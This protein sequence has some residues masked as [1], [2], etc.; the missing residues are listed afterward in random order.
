MNIFSILV[1]KQM[2]TYL[3]AND[4]L[5]SAVEFLLNSGYSAVPVI[6]NE[7]LY[8]GIVSEGD[9]LRL[10][11][12]TGIDNLKNYKVSDLVKIDK[13]GAVLNTVSRDEV[14]EKILDRNF[15][16][17]IDDRGCFVGIITRKSV[18]MSLNKN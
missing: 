3:N 10:I 7:G 6:D 17:V 9:F 15:L 16:A 14:Y 13:D 11:M 8:I 18:I 2:L 12:E 4:S 1:P 5:D